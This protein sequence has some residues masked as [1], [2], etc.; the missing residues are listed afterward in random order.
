G[1]WKHSILQRDRL[2]VYFPMAQRDRYVP[3]GSMFIA[4]RGNPEII[5]NEVRREIQGVRA[6]IPAVTVVR[7]ADV[8]GPE[9][10]PWR[11][12]ATMFGIFGAVSLM[13]AVVGLYGVVTFTAAQRSSE[14]ALRIALGAAAGNVL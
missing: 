1:F 11:L 14:I 4:F 3:A 13:I 9:L 12:A 5:A 2:V 6:D 10:R 7:M 8:V